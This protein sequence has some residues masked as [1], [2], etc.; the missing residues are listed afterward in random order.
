MRLLKLSGYT[1][2]LLVATLVAMSWVPVRGQ[3]GTGASSLA[4]PEAR[5]GP[6]DLLYVSA[7]GTAYIRPHQIGTG[8]LVFDVRNDFQFVKRIPTWDVAASQAPELIVGIAASPATGLLYL[9]TPTRL[10]AFDL[11]T[12]KKAWEQTYDGGCCEMLALAPDGKMIYAAANYKSHWYAVDAMTGTLIKK[13]EYPKDFVGR[14]IERSHNIIWSRDGSRVFMSGSGDRD[15]TM[16]VA[17]AKTH[18]IVKAIGPFSDAIRPFTT[19]GRGTLLFVNMV[20][21]CGFEVADTSTG[22]VLH[23]VECQGNWKEKVNTPGIMLGHGAPSHGVAMSPDEKEIW[24]TDNVEGSLHVFD[25]TVMPPKEVTSVKT[26][27]PPYWV[28]FGLDGKY[29]FAMSGDVIDP[30]TKKVIAVLKDEYG[31]DVYSEKYL[32]ATFVDGK[33]MRATDRFGIGQV[34][35][36]TH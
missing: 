3:Q 30:K 29:V 10:A 5:K 14:K 21:L 1:G 18:T 2:C 32:E 19:N 9:T 13:V 33:M 25:A 4:S 15:N 26:R 36:T 22:K 17:D 24:V 6:R 31:R 27:V 20:G 12:D 35:A 11:R 8:V 28:N 34:L 23:R 7:N 16:A